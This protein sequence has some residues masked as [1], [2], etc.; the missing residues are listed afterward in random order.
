[1]EDPDYD[2]EQLRDRLVAQFDQWE[3]TASADAEAIYARMVLPDDEP[4]AALY[5][6]LLLHEQ[7]K[8]RINFFSLME[9]VEL[10]NRNDKSVRAW[11]QHSSRRVAIDF[12]K[13][14]WEKHRNDYAGNK[15]EF[16]RHYVKRVFNELQVAV[17]EKQMREVWLKDGGGVP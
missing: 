2:F 17:T 1:M 13:T 7:I 4:E 11:K 6:M 3:A 12:V 8:D 15:S 16:S 9:F 14:E 5:Q 10:C